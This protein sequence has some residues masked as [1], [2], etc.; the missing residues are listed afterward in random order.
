MGSPSELVGGSGPE[1][2]ER[3]RCAQPATHR[4][5]QLSGVSRRSMAIL[6]PLQGLVVNGSVR[7]GRRFGRDFEAVH[8]KAVVGSGAQGL[9]P[10]A[11]GV[12][13]LVLA[14]W[15]VDSHGNTA[16]GERERVGAAH[17]EQHLHTDAC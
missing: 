17:A 5:R 10:A 4:L 16:S 3:R 15:N 1:Q 9:R 12:A 13:K 6:G 11:H 7:L 8:G 14:A 2:L